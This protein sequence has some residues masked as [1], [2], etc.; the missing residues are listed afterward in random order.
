M[1]SNRFA[2]LQVPEPEPV[3]NTNKSVGEYMR[4]FIATLDKDDDG[5]DKDMGE[6]KYIA[7]NYFEIC[8]M[9]REFGIYYV[10]DLMF[11]RRIMMNDDLMR[12][13]KNSLKICLR[14]LFTFVDNY[15]PSINYIE[16]FINRPIGNLNSDSLNNNDKLKNYLLENDECKVRELIWGIGNLQYYI[17]N[18]N[19]NMFN[20]ILLEKNNVNYNRNFINNIKNK[21]KYL[22]GVSYDYIHDKSILNAIN[23]FVWSS[24]L[25]NKIGTTDSNK[26]TT[27]CS[28]HTKRNNTDVF[29]EI[30]KIKP[31]EQF[32]GLN[33]IGYK[34][35]RVSWKNTKLSNNSEFMANNHKLSISGFSATTLKILTLINI[36][37]YD[38]NRSINKHIIYA[39]ILYLVPA[40]HSTSEIIAAA[41]LF[42]YFDTQGNRYN[43]YE[44]INMKYH[45]NIHL[46]NNI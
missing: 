15:N 6:K 17:E 29:G 38:D 12:D 40:N 43:M 34:P 16:I 18:K 13:I 27:Y 11:V 20:N 25:I 3:Q 4:E 9:I 26:L 14:K 37:N 33:I 22:Y 24:C 45:L 39:L 41:S 32:D 8:R 46:I 10:E 19:N 42:S 36:F 28:S 7:D 5:K 44:N 1:T 31:F 30:G 21:I 2:P 23:I 35:G